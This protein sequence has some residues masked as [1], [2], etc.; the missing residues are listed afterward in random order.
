V[1]RPR[2]RGPERA[3]RDAAA[4]AAQWESAAVDAA[5]LRHRVR[6]PWWELL[7]ERRITL[8]VSR[9]YE[10]VL[11]AMGAGAEGP[12]ISFLPLPHPSGIAFDRSRRVVHVA[13]TRNPN[14]VFT[15]AP[16][17]GMRPR[18]GVAPDAASGRP[19]VPVAISLYPGCLYLHD[20]AV[21]AGELLAT[22]TGENAVVRLGPDGSFTRV[23]WPRCIEGRGGPVFNRNHIQLNAI[24]AGRTLGGSYFTASS[25]ELGSRRPGHRDYPVDGR[26]VVFSGATRE[27]VAS[28]LTR[29][30]SLKQHRGLLWVANSGHG[31]FGLIRDG[32]FE[33]VAT[34]RGWTRGVCID[35][36]LAFVGTSRVIPRF[37]AYAPGVDLDRSECGVHAVDLKSGAVR[38]SVLWPAGNQ[39][40]AIER[41]PGSFTRGLPLTGRRARRRE[42]DLFHAYKSSTCLS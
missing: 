11:V 12:E 13:S 40:F 34:L 8:L 32:R 19:L 39:I 10:H 20:L 17:T 33:P 23:W 27:P 25:V 31:E 15:F 14:Q 9:E 21:V 2:A 35:G 6:G 1:K 24:A 16:V 22:A 28:G 4:V 18:D 41:V 38:A 29:P 3:W 26:G 42:R 30:H 5:L 37:R 36:D 7:A